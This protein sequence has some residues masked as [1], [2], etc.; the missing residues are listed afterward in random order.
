M[1][2]AWLQ[3][4]V[5]QVACTGSVCAAVF[6]TCGQPSQSDT[7]MST[8]SMAAE[9]KALIASAGPVHA[10]MYAQD[11]FVQQVPDLLAAKSVQTYSC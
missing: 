9:F 1:S 2:K 7:C 11:L 6:W 8:L 3:N 10:N 4:V 5:L